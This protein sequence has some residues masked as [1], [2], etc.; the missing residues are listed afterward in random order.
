MHS[1]LRCP[2]G[3]LAI[4]A[5][6]L[7]ACAPQ[8]RVQPAALKGS[9]EPSYEMLR[10]GD[11]IRLEIWREPDLSGD[12]VVDE[13]GVVVLPLLGPRSVTGLAPDALKAALIEDYAEYLTHRSITVTPMRRINV[14]GAVGQPGLHPVDATMT[15]ADVLAVA[16]GTTTNG[17]PDKIDL[18]RA[19]ERISTR[20]SQQ[21]LI[22]DL[23]IRSGD[24]LYVPE[25][26]WISRNASVVSTIISATVSII[27]AVSR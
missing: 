13:S 11:L 7:L 21:T 12:H 6:L 15:I 9:D 18:L 26:R 23:P 25:R 22:G 8:T 27:L 14:L 16:G 1:L 4:S 17:D 20:L 5:A 24:Q 2:A 19:G 10:S 3:I